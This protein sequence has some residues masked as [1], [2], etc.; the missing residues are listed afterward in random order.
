M[1]CVVMLQ[2]IVRLIKA[3]RCAG[4]RHAT[5]RTAVKIHRTGNLLEVKVSSPALLLLDGLLRLLL[6][7]FSFDALGTPGARVLGGRDGAGRGRGGSGLER[8][9]ARLRRDQ[10]G[11]TARFAL[12]AAVAGEVLAVEVRVL[13]EPGLDEGFGG[14]RVAA[15]TAFRLVDDEGIG[16]CLGHCDGGVEELLWWC[17]EVVEVLLR[18]GQLSS[19]GC[20][21]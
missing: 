1:H 13:Q 9:L 19:G 3:H 20:L 10:A 5:A 2:G 14:I 16:E 8:V 4:S 15:G 21:G 12:V 6:Q 7:A 18:E 17:W 11:A